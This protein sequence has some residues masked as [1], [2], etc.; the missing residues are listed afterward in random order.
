MTDGHGVAEH[1]YYSMGQGADTGRS[2]YKKLH[3]DCASGLMRTWFTSRTPRGWRLQQPRNIR[4]TD[5]GRLLGLLASMKTEV[6]A[7]FNNC[8]WSRMLAKHKLYHV[9]Y[10]LV[11]RLPGNSL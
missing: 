9:W 5:D 1:L 2:L 3:A 10:L 4:H 11:L 7:S 6:S 8:H